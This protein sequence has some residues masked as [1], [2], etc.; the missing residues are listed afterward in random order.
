MINLDD[1]MLPDLSSSCTTD[2]AVA[3]MLGWMH[4]PLRRKYTLVTLNGVSEDQLPLLYSLDVS[5]D[6]QL[7]ELLE[8]AKNALYKA[9]E[10]GASAEGLQELAG[11]VTKKTGVTHITLKS[12]DQ[13]A[14]KEHNIAIIEPSEPLPSVTGEQ[15]G[16]P[17]TGIETGMDRKQDR[18]KQPKLREQEK[19]ILDEIKHL[20]H[21]P[22]HLPENMPG[23]RGVKAEVNNALKGNALFAGTTVFEKA[24]DR[25]RKEGAIANVEKYPPP[26]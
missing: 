9:A 13:W 1:E 24:W 8:A 25:L 22:K 23:K 2:V 17:P 11:V 12:L 7:L 18:E 10:S 14:R 26:K 6:E 16:P 21:D 3:K 5:L 19:I 15:Q 4:G 20:G